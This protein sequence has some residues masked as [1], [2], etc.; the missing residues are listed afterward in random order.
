MADLSAQARVV[1]SGSFNQAVVYGSCGLSD[2]NSSRLLFSSFGSHSRA[3]GSALACLFVSIDYVSSIDIELAHFGLVSPL[4][5]LKGAFGES[6]LGMVI[7]WLG[8]S[9]WS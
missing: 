3:A 4:G 8:V 1:A 2:A 7:N 6:V 9:L 5:F